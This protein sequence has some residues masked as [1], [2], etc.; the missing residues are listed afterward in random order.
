MI[1]QEE[2]DKLNQRVADIEE[3]LPIMA[4]KILDSS[5]VVRIIDE[6]LERKI[7]DLI[8]DKIYSFTTYFESAGVAGDGFTTS[9]AGTGSVANSGEEVL[10]TTGVVSGNTTEIK[11]T[12]INQGF[13]GFNAPSRFRSGFLLSGSATNLT[14]FIIAGYADEYYGFKVAG[15]VLYGVT[16]DNITE[17]AVQLISSVSADLVY[18]IEAK[19]IPGESVVFLVNGK[20]YGVS[21]KNLPRPYLSSGV[22]SLTYLFEIKITTNTAA[23]KYIAVSF[24]DFLQYNTKLSTRQ[25]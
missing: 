5:D 16:Y 20:V 18:N 19:Y 2:I 21:R 9:A 10:L 11:K 7:F 13:L 1:M 22:N 23:A 24:F 3:T 14:A 8:W 4:G 17:N 12:P 25:V 6:H 15:G